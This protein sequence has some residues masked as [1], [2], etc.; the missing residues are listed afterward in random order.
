[1]RA[2][3]AM[4]AMA[5]VWASAWL[6]DRAGLVGKT[7]VFEAAM[8][9]SVFHAADIVHDISYV[10]SIS[11]YLIAV[12]DAAPAIDEAGA[13]LA[14]DALPDTQPQPEPDALSSR[15]AGIGFQT[16]RLLAACAGSYAFAYAARLS[17]T[18]WAV[19]TA[20]V[21]TQPAWA[22]T[23]N[24][25]RNRILGTLLGAL[26]GFLVLEAARHGWPVMPLFWLALVPL[27]AITGAY[28]TM[29]LSC[30]TLAVIVLIPAS[31]PPFLRP[32]DRVAGIMLGVAASLAAS[33]LIRP[34]ALR[35]LVPLR[36]SAATPDES[37]RE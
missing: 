9:L 21:V 15:L 24:S 13:S 27:A 12:L 31:G 18:Y 36:H 26:A 1:M 5:W 34:G 28:Q 17:E 7:A 23:L 32:L 29:R 37:P 30:V 16:L 3:Q 2:T 22:D 4:M 33:A 8:S 14:E 20:A 11:I 35:S 25:S 6:V 10:N 19:I